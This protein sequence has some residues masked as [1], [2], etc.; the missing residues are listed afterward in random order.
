MAS[1]GPL[2]ERDEVVQKLLVSHVEPRSA[3]L[4][5]LV[6]GWCARRGAPET[7]QGVN[8]GIRRW[9]RTLAEIPLSP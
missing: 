5:R 1:A 8:G 2:A 4:S 6:P 9:R 3:H 7:L